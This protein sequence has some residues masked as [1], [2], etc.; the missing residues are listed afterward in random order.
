MGPK[1]QAAA[2]FVAGGGSRAV[3]GDLDEAVAALSGQAGT[4]IVP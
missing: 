1:V 3:I 2:D 4:A